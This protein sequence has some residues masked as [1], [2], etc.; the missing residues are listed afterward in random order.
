MISFAIST[1]IV[2]AFVGQINSGC[3]GIDR[4]GINIF[5]SSCSGGNTAITLII[6]ATTINN[7]VY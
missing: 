2:V 5:G 1:T 6:V 4:I 3:I 7:I